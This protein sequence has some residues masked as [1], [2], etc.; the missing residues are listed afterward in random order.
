MVRIKVDICLPNQSI[1]ATESIANDMLNLPGASGT[2]QDIAYNITQERLNSTAANSN[3][4]A[5]TKERTIFV[6]GSKGVVS[7]FITQL[8]SIT[9]KLQ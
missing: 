1:M 6:L 9:F 5:S 8:K 3:G 2:L 7:I 4:T